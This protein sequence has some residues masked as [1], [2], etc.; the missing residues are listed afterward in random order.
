MRI[1]V[2]AM[3]LVT[4]LAFACE[5]PAPD[6]REWRV[7]DHDQPPSQGQVA[8]SA[9]PPAETAAAGA[10]GLPTTVN[11]AL[12]HR[13][14][15]EQILQ[16]WVERCTSCHG[17]IGRGDGPQGAMFRARDLSDP[18]WQQSVTDASI[19]VSIT[20][21]KGAMPGFA[22]PPETLAGMVRLVRLFAQ[23]SPAPG[24]A[25]PQGAAP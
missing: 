18:G 19:E 11:Q 13:G 5:K 12:A 21:G 23:R 15:N 22:L 20:K 4:T 3:T 7:S 9:P 25:V 2:L 17:T 6:L 10:A 24:T 1:P 14:L 16:V 8:P